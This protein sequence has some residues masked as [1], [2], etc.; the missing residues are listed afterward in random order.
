MECVL[1]A[2]SPG[3]RAGAAAVAAWGRFDTIIWT[4]VGADS[5]GNETPAPSPRAPAQRQRL[6]LFA[7]DRD[8]LGA[9]AH[10]V[11]DREHQVGAVH[12]VEMQFLDAVVDEI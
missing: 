2:Y 6:L 4:R 11:A 8:R 1:R 10:E 12:G 3:G 9:Q 5:D 7:L